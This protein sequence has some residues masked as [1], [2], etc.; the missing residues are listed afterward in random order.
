M[1]HR[2]QHT[3]SLSIINLCFYVQT[4]EINKNAKCVAQINEINPCSMR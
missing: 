3:S 1:V 4:Y 2:K